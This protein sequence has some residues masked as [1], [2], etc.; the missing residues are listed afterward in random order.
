ME[1]NGHNN[2]DAHIITTK[3]LMNK[4]A[5]VTGGA[6]GIGGATAKLMAEN[7]AHV[8]IADILDD[9][10]TSLANSIN[11]RFIHC[12]VSIESDVEAAVQLAITWKG[13]LDIMYNNAGIGVEGGSITT[14]DMKKIQKVIGVN[15]NGVLHGTKHAARAMISRGKGGAIIN[16]SSTAAIMGGLGSHTY[17]LT[18]EAILGLTRSSSCE[19]GT[20]GIRVN[21]VLPHAVL[22]RM[23]VESYRGFVKDITAEE[24]QQKM[25]ENASLLKGRCGLVEDVAYAVVYLASDEAGFITGHNLVIDGGYTSSSVGMTFIYREKKRK[26]Q[27]N[28]AS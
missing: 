13:K 26:N 24:V 3:R 15:M 19:L 16:S 1:Q 9:L 23:L 22:S 11:G 4:V 8:V 28:L 27:I 14:L 6:R 5:V 7:G 20:Y 17:T 12:D 10:G 21:C 25:G 2:G 18:K